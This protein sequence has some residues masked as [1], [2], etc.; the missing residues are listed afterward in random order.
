MMPRPA[1]LDSPYVAV[2]QG[3]HGIAYRVSD[4]APADER[5]RLEAE[6]RAYEKA[7]RAIHKLML[8]DKS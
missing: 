2:K 4:E 7:Y 6:I 1:F 5:D 3:R 8:D